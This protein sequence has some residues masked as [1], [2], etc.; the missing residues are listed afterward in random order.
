MR[1]AKGMVVGLV[2]MFAWLEAVS[3]NAAQREVWS[4]EDESGLGGLARSVRMD[5]NGDALYLWFSGTNSFLVKAS[6]GSGAVLWQAAVPAE[7]WRVELD[8]EGNSIVT[9]KRKAPNGE[10]SVYTAKFAADSG[11]VL[12]ERE[13]NEAG[14]TTPVPNV[15]VDPSGNVVLL[16]SLKNANGSYS[17]LVEYASTNGAVRWEKRIEDPSGAVAVMAL[18]LGTNGDVAVGGSIHTNLF[19]AKFANE[20][21]E[22]LWGRQHAH[23]NKDGAFI[24]S[25]AVDRDGNVAMTGGAVYSGPQKGQIYTGRFAASNGNALWEVWTPRSRRATDV[26]VYV[27]TTED[28]DVIVAGVYSPEDIMLLEDVL[29]VRYRALNG[30][31]VWEKNQRI[32]TGLIGGVSEEPTGLTLDSEGNLVVGVTAISFTF[33]T[34][35]SSTVKLNA[36]DGAQIWEA[37]HL[38]DYIPNFVLGANDQI[39]VSGQERHRTAIVR[40]LRVGPELTIE[41]I[42]S[43]FEIGW[44][45][46]YVGWSL[47]KLSSSEAGP[48]WV[49]VIG[50]QATTSQRVPKT[51][52]EV[53]IFRLVKD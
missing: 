47:Q 7:A 11:S 16:G 13:L 26:G 28:G 21:G 23:T 50:S 42:G 32:S 12:W 35:R 44:E 52:P 14:A 8:A 25:V 2:T 33:Q 4:R 18:A 30:E 5:G 3:A 27:L 37:I 39:L 45:P 29:V 34:S 31:I 43:E 6:G 46:Q 36:A 24:S 53:G 15:K 48:S 19:V 17:V 38:D 9:G 20:N 51:N 41:Q 49:D 10:Y 40:L 22:L 1:I